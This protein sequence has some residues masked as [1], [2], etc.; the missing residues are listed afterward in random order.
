MMCLRCLLF[1]G[2]SVRRSDRNGQMSALFLYLALL[3][4]ILY[5]FFSVMFLM[6]LSFVFQ[7]ICSWIL[8]VVSLLFST[9]ISPCPMNFRELFSSSAKW[10]PSEGGSS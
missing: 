9:I 1:G 4:P 10:L 7:L 6:S 3:G 8:S 5:C 2:S